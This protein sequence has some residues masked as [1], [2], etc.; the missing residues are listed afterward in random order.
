MSEVVAG[1]VAAEL[2]KVERSNGSTGSYARVDFDPRCENAINEQ[3]NIE[4][5]ASYVYHALFAHFNADNV[6]LPGFAEFFRNSSLEE[7]SHAELLMKY[8]N[9]RGGKVVLRGINLPQMKM[10]GN[11]K[12]DALYALELALALEKLNF[13]KLR[14]LDDVA[15]QAGDKAMGSFIESKLLEEQSED[16]KD[17][18]D[19]VARLRRIG[20]EGT[21]IYLFDKEMAEAAAKILQSAE[22]NMGH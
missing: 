11:D 15:D 20:D 16:V 12:G 14:E 19:R 22:E 5:T 6:G 4:Y 7:R 9:E 10:D 8:Q 21:G 2:E 3:I 18:A 13:T 17:A 1:G